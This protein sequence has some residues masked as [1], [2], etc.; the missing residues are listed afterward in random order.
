MD[1]S[2][3]DDILS[4]MNYIKTVNLKGKVDIEEHFFWWNLGNIELYFCIDTN[5]T[6]VSYY[7][8]GHK[9]HYL[10]HFH[11]DNS[12]VVNLIQDINSESKI[13]QITYSFLGSGFSVIDKTAEKKKSWFLCRRYYS[14]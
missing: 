9:L 12:D 13:I 6:T 5:E 11:I 10:G 4:I 1:N 2:G 3:Q 14:C 7:R 8:N